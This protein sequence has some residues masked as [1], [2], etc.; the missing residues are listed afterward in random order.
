MSTL[1][2]CLSIYYHYNH[3]IRQLSILRKYSKVEINQFFSIFDSNCEQEFWK[4]KFIWPLCRCNNVE[5]FCCFNRIEILMHFNAMTTIFNFQTHA[6]VH[7]HTHT[8]VLEAIV[9]S[10]IIST[11][12]LNYGPFCRLLHPWLLDSL[13]KK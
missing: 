12:T 9:Y 4:R 6:L 2:I 3:Q 7:T 11:F 8:V 1:Q 10:M 5:Y 13:L